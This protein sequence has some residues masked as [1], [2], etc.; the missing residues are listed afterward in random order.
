[1]NE[2][3]QWWQSRTVWAGLIGMLF[4]VLSG[5]GLVPE[6]LTQ[7]MVLEA[8]IATV[9]VAAIVFRVQATKVI[10]KPTKE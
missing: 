9:S 1:M 8:V 6:G 10:A 3:I 4:A 2:Q 7:E 5:L